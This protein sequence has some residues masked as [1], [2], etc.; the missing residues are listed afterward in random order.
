MGQEVA[1]RV[2]SREDRQRYRHKVRACLDV[3]ARMLAEARFDAD[4]R[5]FGLEV[6]LKL[7]DEGGDPA[8]VNA[9]ALEAIADPDFQ[10]E[11]AQFNVEINVAPR[12]LGG[13][14][15]CDLET[16]VRA[17]LNTAESRAQSVAA[18]MMLIGILPTI[19]DAHLNADSFSASSRYALLNEQIFAA[20]GED[21]HINIAGAGGERLS[22]YADTIA[23]EA[24]CTSVQLHQQVDPEDFARHWNAAQAIAG[25]QMAIGA[26][27]P[28][29]FGRELWRETRIALFEQATDTRPEE[30]KAQGVRPRVWFGERWITSIF[31]QFEE[32][33][34]YFPSLLPIVDEE[35]PAE[36][37]DRGD[38]PRLGE[39]RMHIGTIYRW[40]RPVYDVYRGKPHLRVEH[41]VLPAGPSVVDVLANGAFYYGLLRTLTQ[42]DRPTWTRMS[43]TAAE[44]NFTAGA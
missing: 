41:R 33:V 22:T 35:D 1:P 13:D 39:L 44:D 19:T 40:N 31:D 11:L 42:E 17:S 24:A 36:V 4:R 23:P 29:F 2:F 27:S 28:F 30:L 12:L 15:L 7:T 37:L 18:H 43:F 5:S 38:T 6:E 26:N 10:T 21:L 3:F 16:A 32:N 8:L 34:R 14:V 20:R 25:V 9:H